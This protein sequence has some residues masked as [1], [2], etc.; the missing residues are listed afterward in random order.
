MEGQ[1][2]ME[3]YSLPLSP[4]PPPLRRHG[5]QLERLANGYYRAH[6]RVDDTMNLGGIKVSATDIERTINTVEAIHEA[7]AI[8]ISP[9]E[10]GPSQLVIYAV[11]T[12]TFQGNLDELQSSL[13][14]SIRQYLNPL[15][16]IYDVVIVDALPR[17]ASNKVM[18]R[19]LREQYRG[20]GKRQEAGGRMEG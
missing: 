20:G 6:G 5:D 14:A 10:G 1:W 15:F 4:S 2:D 18:R 11:V 3:R 9:P 8:A 12:P 16:K 17:T 7:A 13:Q 19:V